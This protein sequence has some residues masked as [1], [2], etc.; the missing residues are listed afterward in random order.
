MAASAAN[1]QTELENAAQVIMAPPTMVTVEQ[2]HSAEHVLLSFKKSK[3]PFATCKHILESSKVDYVLFQAAST[4]KEAV[5]REWSLLD[6]S[7]VESMRSFL[8]R[9][10]TQKPHLQS[11]VREQILQA[12]AV[13][14]KRGTVDHKTTE[15][16]GIYNDV[17]ELIASGDSSLQL[18]AC[19]ILIALLNEYSSSSRSS[20]VGLS[21]E[22]HATCKKAFENNDLKRVFLF[23]VQVLHQFA[24]NDILSRETTAVFNRFLSIS[25]QVLSWDFTHANVLRRNVGSFDSNQGTF[26]KPIATWRGTVL[27][28]NL[29]DLFFKL[30]LKVRHNSEM[31]HH[32]LQCLTQLASLSGNIFPDEKTQCEYLGRYIQGFLHFINSVEV[33]DHEALG[34]SNIINRLVTVFP[35][36][37][38]VRLPLELLDPFIHT[39]AELTCQFGR[40]AALEEA[41]HK[42]DMIHMEAFDQLL[43]AWTTLLMDTQYFQSGYFK[44]HAM[45][46]F[47][48]YVQCHLAVPDGTRNQL[49]NLYEDIHWLVLIS[50]YVLADEPQ[51][52]TPLIPP[53]IMEY[54][55]A[56]SQNVDIDTTLRVLGSPGEKV[57][58]IPMS[59]QSSDKVIRLISAVFRLSEVERRAVNAQL[60]SLL[61]PQ[62]GATTM[63]FLRR[64]SLSYIMPNERYYTQMSL[65]LAVAFGRDTDGAQWSI[66]FLVDKIVSNLSVWSAE[67]DLS[68]DTVNLLV[69]LVQQKESLTAQHSL[70]TGFLSQHK[71]AVLQPVQHRFNHLL[72]QD[73]FQRI[74]QDENIKTEIV[75]LLS[76]LEGA[77]M[78][79]RIDNVSTVFSFSLPLL[80]E[81]V[82]LLGT[83]HNCPEVVVVILEVF[84][85]MANRMICYL[86]E[87]DTNK[88]YDVSISLLQTYSKY[89]TGKKHFEI[90]AEEDHYQD[91]S[92]MMELLTHLLSKDF[93]DFGITEDIASGE[94]DQISANVSAADIVLYGLNIIVPLMNAEL[95]KFPTLCSQYYKLI[96]FI[97][98]IYPEKI[99]Q[100]PEQLFKSL[101]GSIELGLTS[102]GL[103]V[104][105]LCFDSIS[106]LGEYEYKEHDNNVQLVAATQHFLKVVFDILLYQN[107]DME[108]TSP[109]SEAFFALM[110]CHQVQYNELVHSLVGSQTD[111]SYYQRLA[112]A[113]NQLT[114]PNEPLVI[115]RPHK[116]AFLRKMETF[117]VNVRGFLCVK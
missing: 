22:F 88:V 80:N 112:D 68:T 94:G 40:K 97:C 11:Y 19:S 18:V 53:E 98:E 64:W 7:E 31:G 91:I 43:D 79:T 49:G 59:E 115:N 21:W 3:S 17:T 102:F 74:Y 9:Y 109:A 82:S 65:P 12:V 44:P 13:I 28:Q 66:G 100:L 81:C 103:E 89:N 111:P 104:T 57:T 23:S 25:E 69:A 55:I 90:T 96:S 76:M 99:C 35:I 26:F 77:I 34:I 60:T 50:G 75:T 29:V 48:T 95:L 58:S 27:D 38:M 5:A 72:Q 42:D 56:E 1:I 85:V 86:S 61:S 20:D 62:V 24:N 16:E 110:C 116:L 6:M 41:I 113:F 78:G 30:H 106:A 70:F 4:I 36:G 33:A 117:L 37:V 84:T 14:V 45:E 87:N 54:S 15:R 2:R 107:F 51:G 10:V 39:L 73:N 52:E 71:K 114:P 47:N 8:L 105:K 101:L 63:W 93:V 83:Y 108:L 67:H 32:S 46:V 92:L